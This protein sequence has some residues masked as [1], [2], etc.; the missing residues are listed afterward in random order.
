MFLS[1]CLDPNIACNGSFINDTCDINTGASCEVST[2][3]GL[4]C[5]CSDSYDALPYYGATS[6]I[7]KCMKLKC[8]NSPSDWMTTINAKEMLKKW[9]KETSNDRAKETVTYRL[10]HSGFLLMCI[11]SWQKS[12]VKMMEIVPEE[13]FMVLVILMAV[14]MLT[15][16]VNVTGVSQ[17]PLVKIVSCLVEFIFGNHLS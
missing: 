9:D 3:G 4:R 16:T 12:S 1:C 5:T 10:Y 15:I 13:A 6:C 7:S 8:V 11:S 17:G 14:M 2:A